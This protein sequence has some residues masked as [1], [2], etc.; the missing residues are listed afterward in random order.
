M[1]FVGGRLGSNRGHG[2]VDGGRRAGHR[3]FMPLLA[4]PEFKATAD[5]RPVR[6]GPDE[7]PPFGFWGYFESIPHP[8]F[9]GH[10]FSAGIVTYV[11][12][13]PAT[14]CQHVLVNCETENVF[15]VLVLD[16]RHS[17]V[18]GHHLLDLRKLY[19]LI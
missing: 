1:T 5:P 13:M 11:W 8:D 19:G 17:E 12:T 6:V 9:D 2:T 3:G 7:S 18:R 10:D 14:D 16:L 15:L 4:N